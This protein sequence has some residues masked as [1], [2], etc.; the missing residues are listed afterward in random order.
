[1]TEYIKSVA[2]FLKRYW[3]LLAVGMVL[4]KYSVEYAYQE[5]GYWAVG[6]EYL[7]I[8]MLLMVACLAES[9]IREIRETFAFDYDEEDSDGDYGWNKKHHLGFSEESE[10]RR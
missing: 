7:V 5:R 10:H 6:G 4:T 1:M 2:K 3:W 9:I 8:P